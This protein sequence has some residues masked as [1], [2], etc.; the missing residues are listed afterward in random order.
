MTATDVTATTQADHA[1]HAPATRESR[2]EAVLFL[3]AALLLVIG[4]INTVAFGPVGLAMTALALV[5]VCYFMILWITV[6][7]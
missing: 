3:V 1:D 5:P 4:A 6:G 2:G 7:K